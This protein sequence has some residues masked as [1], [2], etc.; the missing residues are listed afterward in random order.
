VGRVIA[1][2]FLF[3]L[4]GAAPC[5]MPPLRLRGRSAK[6]TTAA[7]FA[8]F[9]AVLAAVG[10]RRI[11]NTLVADTLLAL[12]FSASLYALLH[13]RAPGRSGI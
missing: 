2:Y 6:V 12:T 9:F 7:L 8:L 5:L 3:W 11:P 13:H 4:M 10:L 1:L